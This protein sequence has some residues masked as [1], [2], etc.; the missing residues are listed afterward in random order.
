MAH[1]HNVIEAYCKICGKAITQA[2]IDGKMA[3]K[4]DDNWVHIFHTQEAQKI[5][6]DEKY[7]DGV[8]EFV[9]MM[10]KKEDRNISG[11]MIKKEAM[12][13]ANRRELDFDKLELAVA[14]FYSY[15]V[16]MAEKRTM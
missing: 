13:I 14:A 12:A 9:N 11:E 15:S 1:G 16:A 4:I 10:T 2:V 7:M 6:S 8:E 5:L 3:V